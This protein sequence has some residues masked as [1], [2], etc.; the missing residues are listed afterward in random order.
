MLPLKVLERGADWVPRVAPRILI[1]DNDSSAR[2]QMAGWLEGAGFACARTDTGDALAEARRHQ[3]EVAVVGV[4]VPDDGGMWIV[5]SLRTQ[6]DPVG[7]VV[8]S[9][10]PNFD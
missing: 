4:N 7:V 10:T 2:N 1:A 6:P 9:S 3:P 8:M 5:R